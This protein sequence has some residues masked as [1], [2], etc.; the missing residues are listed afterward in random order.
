MYITR[1]SIVVMMGWLILCMTGKLGNIANT[2]H[3]AG[4]AV[5]MLSGYVSAWWNGFGT[6]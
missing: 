1:G 3:L 5:G 2:A 4:L 6:A